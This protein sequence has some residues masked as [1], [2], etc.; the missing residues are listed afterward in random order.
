MPAVVLTGAR[1]TGKSTLVERLLPGHRRYRTLDEFDVLELATAN[2][3]AI[4]G[5]DEPLT[6]DEIQRAPELLLAVKR[7]ID[8]D[9]RP[10]R[11]LLTGSAN[12]LLMQGVSESL[13]GRASYLTLWPMSLGETRGTGR[14][15][16]WNELL[17]VSPKEWPSLLHDLGNTPADWREVV[18]RG[19]YPTPSVHLKSE[20][21]RGIWFDG[22]V[23]TY[24]ERD[25]NALTSVTSLA[26]FRRLMRAACLRVGQMLNQTE[27]GRD[28]GLSQPTVHRWF[29]VL[30]ASY[31]LVRVPAYSR[32]RTKRLIKSPKIYWADTGLAM[33]LAGTAEP[34][35]AMLENLVLLDMLVCRDSRANPLDISYWRT[36]TGEEV[37]FV[38]EGHGR[39]LPVEVKATERPNLRDARHLI[40]FCDEYGSEAPAALLLHCGTVSEWLTPQVFATPWWTTT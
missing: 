17:S 8:T 10:G 18:T 25:L 4:L 22:Y 39:L 34:S 33:R 7:S 31:Q 6:I 30:E 13:A 32:N 16:A 29:N 9:R 19:G 15:G 40:S 3:Q 1:Q 21:E 28:T 35:G 36:A 2:P 5:G 20:E 26:D 27:L 24:L 12:L 11:F 38:L 37:D 14:C 23:R